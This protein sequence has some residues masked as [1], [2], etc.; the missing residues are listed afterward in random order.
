MQQV[1]IRSEGKTKCVLVNCV[2]YCCSDRYREPSGRLKETELM[3][4]FNEFL[5]PQLH[6]AVSKLLIRE[7]VR[8]KIDPQNF[9]R[10]SWD[11]SDFAIARKLWAAV[12]PWR[13]SRKYSES[14]HEARAAAATLA[15][16]IEVEMEPE[17]ETYELLSAQEMHD[18]ICPDGDKCEHAID[19]QESP[20]DAEDKLDEIANAIIEA[21]LRDKIGVKEINKKLCKAVNENTILNSKP[22][23]DYIESQR[24]D[25]RKQHEVAKV[26]CV[27]PSAISKV[28]GPNGII[29]DSRKRNFE[30][31]HSQE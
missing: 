13:E 6:R 15:A 21:G 17:N 31:L 26:L 20:T 7:M 27:S 16:Y 12:D 10:A 14:I 24:A 8:R 1:G 4:D 29:F 9:V 3:L 22:C 19:S 2:P 25:G 5:L 18:L 11:A 23:L 28:A 30:K